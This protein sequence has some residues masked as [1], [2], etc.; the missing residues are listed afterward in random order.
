MAGLAAKAW[1]RLGEARVAGCLMFVALT[2]AGEE[3]T[4]AYA[5]LEVSGYSGCNWVAVA[6]AIALAEA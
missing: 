1:A 4:E 2:Y 5:N 6:E 3:D